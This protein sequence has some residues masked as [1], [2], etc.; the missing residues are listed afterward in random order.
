MFGKTAERPTP[1]VGNNGAGRF[2]FTNVYKFK[3][4]VREGDAKHEVVHTL[5]AF[6][7]ETYAFYEAGL[8]AAITDTEPN[9][10]ERLSRINALHRALWNQLVLSVE[11]Y[12]GITDGETLTD[13]Q[14][15]Q[16]RIKHISGALALLLEQ[17]GI[18]G[19]EVQKN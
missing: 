19:G 13:E 11:N 2:T 14:K 18:E 4:Q 12:D 17:E 10:T 15:A 9:S 7:D 5:R 6:D 1:I 3:M 16:M 8:L